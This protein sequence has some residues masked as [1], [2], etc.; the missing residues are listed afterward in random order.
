M[1]TVFKIFAKADIEAEN[2]EPCSE[3]KFKSREVAEN[4]IKNVMEPNDKECG[5]YEPGYYCVED[6]SK[7]YN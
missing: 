5:V 4:Y 6:I 1:K 7:Y 2:W 3:R